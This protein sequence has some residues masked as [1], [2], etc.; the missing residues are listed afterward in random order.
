MMS[1]TGKKRSPR[2]HGLENAV[3]LLLTQIVRDPVVFSHK[4]HQAFGLMRVEI[5]GDEMPP[6]RLG[7][8]G[9]RVGNVRQ[10][11]LFGP[12]WPHIWRNDPPPR[13][14]EIGD[15][16]QRATPYVLELT[17]LRA[18]RA[19]GDGGMFT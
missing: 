10:E 5:I 7:I 16:R 18:A 15:Q 12:C 17:S 19:H 4:A 6:G 9:H 8:R 13:D 3:L 2:G 1:R 14:I 11:V